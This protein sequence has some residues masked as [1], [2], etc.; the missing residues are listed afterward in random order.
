MDFVDLS[1]LALRLRLANFMRASGSRAGSVE[2]LH[3]RVREAVL[4]HLP[5]GQRRGSHRRLAV[6]LEASGNAEPEQLA[7]QWQ[8]AGDHARATQ[9]FTCAGD[10][11]ADALAFDRASRLYRAALELCGGAD[12]DARALRMK[13]GQALANAG[14]GA[15]AATVYREA[16]IGADPSLGLELKRRAVEQY[17]ISGHLDEG[18]ELVR[19]V[20]AILGM[21][22]PETPRRALLSL[23]ASRARLRLRGTSFKPR[24]ATQMTPDELAR[25][26]VCWSVTYGLAMC[27]HIRGIDFQARGLLRAL[28]SGEP[29]RA[30]R[31]LTSEALARAVAGTFAAK[32]SERVMRQAQALAERLDQ[33]YTVAFGIG[34]EGM[35]AYF[36]GRF[37][38]ARERCGAA[39][40]LF[41]DRCA[42]VPFE[43]A[44]VHL[45][46][47]WGLYYMGDI[48][49]LFQRTSSLLLEAQQRGDLYALTNFRLGAPNIG[50]LLCDGIDEARE[51]GRDA[52]AHWPPSSGVHVQ[53]AFELFSQASADLYAGEP[54]VGLARIRERWPRLKSVFLL[55]VQVVR[56]VLTELAGR[57]ALAAAAAG[58][59]ERRSLIRA[60]LRAARKL[61]RERAPW[62]A[63]MALLL[64]AVAA[65]LK[66]DREAT[67]RL[68]TDA[69]A[70]LLA[71]DMRLHATCAR[72]RRGELCGDSELVAA[73][74]TWMRE[75]SIRE[76]ERA[77]AMFVPRSREKDRLENP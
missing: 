65:D 72:R 21:K 57:V 40:R 76:P 5:E 33:P 29:Y 9:Y 41:R 77:A 45:L 48:R 8:G 73:C 50:W 28:Q 44:T 14:C 69:E 24:P 42:G 34:I 71:V 10:Q 1:R 19:S 7:V 66:G 22:F 49:E 62:A 18:L 46:Q 52:M 43:L 16:S 75:Q 56:I 55:R 35:V 61:R 12:P 15:E 67:L 23:L 31:A 47:L 20:L 74:D 11:A 37:A 36:E 25:I 3:D 32:R 39:E 60:G 2:L 6:A 17:L 63:A 30:C 58:V 64:L 70:A 68:L 54:E 13:L 51:L 53:H 59:E 27:D 26:D 4:S 38:V